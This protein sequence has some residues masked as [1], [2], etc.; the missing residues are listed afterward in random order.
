MTEIAEPRF[1]TG[2]IDSRE[3][4]DAVAAILDEKNGRD[5]RMLRVNEKTTVTDFFVICTANSS[6]QVKSICAEVEY[7]LSE[8]G[9][10]P[11]HIEG[12]DEGS[13]AVLDFLYVIVHIFKADQR[14]F[15]KLEKLWGDCEEIPVK[16]TQK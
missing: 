5:I 10:P 15:Y 9:L 3:V 7:K 2:N 8:R 14:E 11:A 12:Y 4:A 6:T 13:W 16:I 1:D